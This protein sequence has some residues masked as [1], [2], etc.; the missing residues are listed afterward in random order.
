MRSVLLLLCLVCG[1]LSA[2]QSVGIFTFPN[3]GIVWDPDS[4]QNGI[5]GSEEAVIYVGQ[6]LANLGYRVVVFGSPPEGSRYRASDANPRYVSHDQA[7]S[8]I[9]DIAISWRQAD[10]AARLKKRARTVYL[11]PHDT[12][13]WQ[14]PAALVDGF[15][16]VLWLSQWQRDQWIS[17][18]PRFAKFTHIFGNGI[19]PDQFQP[20]KART[21]PYA[22]IYGSNYARGLEHLLDIWPQVKER[23]PLATLDI[24]YGWQHWGLLS[25]EKETKLRNQ[26]ATLPGVRDHGRVGHEELNRAYEQASLWTYPCTAPECFPIT[27]LRAQLAGAVPVI[28]EGT[29]LSGV[30]RGGHKCAQAADYLPTLLQAMERAEKISLEERQQLGQFVMNE[31]TWK[32]VA[33]RWKDL[34][35]ATL[36]ERKP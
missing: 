11:W 9:F 2:Q 36:E 28:I 29:G 6:E 23:F 32:A 3:Q 27:A 21:N 19:V 22:C 18:N 34:F 4:V 33:T 15:D 14:L 20:I 25:P 26:V 1:A 35:D 16:D 10:A 17:V 31:F 30:V 24:Y 8:T 12:F 5:T 13:H 7:D